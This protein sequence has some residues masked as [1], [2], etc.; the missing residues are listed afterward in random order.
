MKYYGYHIVPGG[1]SKSPRWVH[2][3]KCAWCPNYSFPSRP[4]FLN[5]NCL[6]AWYSTG[7]LLSQSPTSCTG[8]HL[9]WLQKHRQRAMGKKLTSFHLATSPYSLVR[10]SLNFIYLLQLLQIHALIYFNH[11]MRFN[12]V[13][14]LEDLIPWWPWWRS[15]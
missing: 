1:G 6:A 2:G 12:E 4:T 11:V 13:K 5:I 3:D 15:A 9:T 14:K 10:N 7:P 8:I